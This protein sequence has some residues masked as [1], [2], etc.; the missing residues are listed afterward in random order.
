MSDENSFKMTQPAS[1]ACGVE[2]SDSEQLAE[3]PRALYI[4][5]G[6]D[7]AVVMKS[8]AEVTLQ[9]F[10]GGII[11]IRVRQVKATGT[12]ADGIVGLF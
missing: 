6:G 10:A 11:P 2:P 1:H 8:G 4:G 9:V 5:T 12:T 7:L 3:I